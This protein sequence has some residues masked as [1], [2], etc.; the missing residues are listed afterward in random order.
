MVIC[1]G[2][3]HM[4]EKVQDRVQVEV[5]RE[6]QGEEETHGKGTKRGTEK[7]QTINQTLI[8]NDLGDDMTR[9]CRHLSQ[10][11]VIHIIMHAHFCIRKMT[12]EV[13]LCL[14]TPS[15]SGSPST[16]NETNCHKKIIHLF[17]F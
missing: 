1:L 2:V 6:E 17:L 11:G 13:F 8:M 16:V 12:C 5:G 15:V 9:S 10:C 3:I 4:E 7:E 14:H